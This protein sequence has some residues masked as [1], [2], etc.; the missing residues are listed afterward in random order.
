MV[1]THAE[2]ADNCTMIPK[3]SIAEFRN[4]YWCRKQLKGIISTTKKFHGPKQT[5]FNA[6]DKKCFGVFARNT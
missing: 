4:V 6:T 2:E 3:F 1:I 5:N